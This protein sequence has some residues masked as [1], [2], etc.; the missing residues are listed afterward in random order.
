MVDCDRLKELNDVQGHAYG[1]QA[2]QSLVRILE[3]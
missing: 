3:R 1:D 2:L